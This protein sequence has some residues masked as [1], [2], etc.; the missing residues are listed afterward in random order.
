[1]QTPPPLPVD[2]SK[3][4]DITEP[5][6]LVE[7]ILALTQDNEDLE[8]E[9]RMFLLK[10]HASTPG[11]AMQA[12]DE[13]A[14]SLWNSIELDLSDMDEYGGA[15]DE[16][17]EKVWCALDELAQTVADG[18]ASVAC[19][20]EMQ[21]L[22]MRYLVSNNAGM[23]DALTE[24]VMACCHS[25]DEW[26]SLAQVFE[27]WSS[28]YWDAQAM[29]IFR[30]I[31]DDEKYL[32][33][34][35]AHLDSASD[36]LDLASYYQAQGKQQQAVQLVESALEIGR[37]ALRPDPRWHLG[38]LMEFL[39]EH[40][41]Q[42]G[43]RQRHTALEFERTVLGLHLDSYL[44]FE[45][46]CEPAE[47]EQFEPQLMKH[48]PSAWPSSQ[49]DIYLH[50]QEHAQA[51]AVLTNSSINVNRGLD[52]TQRRQARLLEPYYPHE[53]LDLYVAKLGK[54]ERDKRSVYAEKA[55]QL[56]DIQRMMLEIMKEEDRWQMMVAEV[57]Q[58]THN[59][60][61]CRDEL[62]KLVPG[63]PSR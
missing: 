8:H 30:Q 54:F 34:R 7:M 29:A 31:G 56:C 26:R 3:L 53:I 47:W 28:S 49:V 14:W 24:L 13:Q 1:M 59:L 16:V 17:V 41:R 39:S 9:C 63:W 10:R 20:Q 35:K 45:K 21:S 57:L 55:K 48:L 36:Y 37:Q 18:K 61:A 2:L 25:P 27:G 33:M 22:A 58:A 62:Q 43:D 51:L 12:A 44:D 23:G 42:T 38:G 40:A 6:I 50:R 52:S 46:H 15:D 4:L 32:A 11:H 5:Q 60:P 19:R